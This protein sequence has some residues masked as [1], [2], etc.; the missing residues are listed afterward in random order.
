MPNS[1]FS[2]QIAL[3]R[4]ESLQFSIKYGNPSYNI[5][6]L[7]RSNFQRKK[8]LRPNNLLFLCLLVCVVR[9]L[10]HYKRMTYVL[11]KSP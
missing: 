9:K 2:S 6:M 11:S 1:I 10:L 8:Q 5:R 3:N 4:T 7:V